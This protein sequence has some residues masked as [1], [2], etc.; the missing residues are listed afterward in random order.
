MPCS[1]I[2]RFC[3]NRIFGR[4]IALLRFGPY[5]VICIY[6]VENR[7]LRSY[8]L[9][10]MLGIILKWFLAIFWKKIFFDFFPAKI[11]KIA[12]KKVKFSESRPISGQ[13]ILK[14]CLGGSSHFHIKFAVNR[15]EDFF[16]YIAFCGKVPIW[17]KPHVIPKYHFGYKKAPKIWKFSNFLK[18]Q[19]LSFLTHLKSLKNLY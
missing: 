6:I 10:L 15:S 8:L 2:L 13:K 1:S 17:R 14:M 19:N 18:V 12:Q 3:E 7:Q 11:L 16:L 5:G 9:I 4:K